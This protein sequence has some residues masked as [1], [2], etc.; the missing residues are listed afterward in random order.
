MK[1]SRLKNIY[2]LLKR[3]CENPEHNHYDRYGGRGI[4]I[5]EDWKNSYKKFE[6]WALSHGYK[7]NLT[8]DRIDNSGNYNPENCKWST[9]Q[10]QANN[11]CTSHL[12]THDG[13][14]KS[15]AQWAR[16]T[17]MTDARLR[18][19]IGAGWEIDK[20]LTEPCSSKRRVAEYTY[21]GVTKRLFEWAKDFG[22][23]YR[24]LENRLNMRGWSIEKALET[25]IKK[26]GGN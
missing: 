6:T 1:N 20:A 5:C 11:R 16:D 3:R 8:L 12:L 7:E 25:P 15:I 18:Q 24:T 14:T 17:G 10:E 2:K 26:K 13:E 19:R 9:W 4:D 21:K 23:N 22:I